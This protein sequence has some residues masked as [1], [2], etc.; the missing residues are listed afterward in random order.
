MLLDVG[1]EHFVNTDDVLAIIP[2]L[3]TNK[4][5]TAFLKYYENE[6]KLFRFNS[7][8]KRKSLILTKSG[9]AIIT[10]FTSTTIADRF[11]NAKIQATQ[12]EVS[13]AKKLRAEN[14]RSYKKQ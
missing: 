7:G 14:A 4:A 10:A 2:C 1:F 8:N 5:M 13:Y 3:A 6:N 11:K 9:Y 12:E